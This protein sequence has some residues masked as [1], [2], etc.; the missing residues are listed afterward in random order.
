MECLWGIP[1]PH[2]N[3]QGTFDNG[4]VIA[5]L[6]GK[7]GTTIIISPDDHHDITIIEVSRVGALIMVC[8]LAAW[9]QVGRYFTE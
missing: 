9:S 5:I 4:I 7:V 3:P 1:L 2:G 6:T 8:R